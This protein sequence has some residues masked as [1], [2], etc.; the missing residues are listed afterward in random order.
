MIDENYYCRQ[1]IHWIVWEGER[2]ILEWN[3]EL[4]GPVS[5]SNIR[6]KPQNLD[7][8][9]RLYQLFPPTLHPSTNPP[10]QPQTRHPKHHLFQPFPPPKKL[11]SLKLQHPSPIEPTDKRYYS[12]RTHSHSH[13]KASM[14]GAWSQFK[15]LAT[16]CERCFDL[17]QRA[18]FEPSCKDVR[19]E[20]SLAAPMGI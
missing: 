9:F 11:T 2:P 15:S 8:H 14:S 10:P 19:S 5:W 7:R 4:Q 20:D 12:I 17:V 1:I 6:A 16:M 18:R 3:T 13:A